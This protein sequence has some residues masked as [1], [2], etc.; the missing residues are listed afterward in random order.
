MVFK[1]LRGAAKMMRHGEALQDALA[2]A[3][4]VVVD[5]P[6]SAA[7][8]AVEAA[9]AGDHRPAADLLQRTLDTRAWDDRSHVVDVLAGASLRAPQ[10]LDDWES[11]APD[12]GGLA[13]VRAATGIH[14]A[15]EHRSRLRASD[16][17]Q[18]QLEAFH[19]TLA[20][21]T[22]LLQRAADLLPDDPEPWALALVHARGLEAPPEVWH[23]YLSR[24]R[25]ADP[26]HYGGHRAAMELLTAKWFG[27]HEEMS[28]FARRVAAEAP[29]DARVR[30]LPL[31]AVV[32]QIASGDAAA[33]AADPA[34]PEAVDLALA[35]VEAGP[36][37]GQHVVA[38]H[39][40][41]LVFVLFHC[42]S[43]R[44]AYD[45]LVATGPFATSVPW[46]YYGEART[47]FLEYRGHVVVKTAETM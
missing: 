25:A 24:V 6:T 34:T 47:V 5:A 43:F 46:G 14:R 4:S 13:L 15:W 28:D 21:T 11:A 17:S 22:A 39:R 9:L 44:Q 16:V 2:P 35:W 38:V 3:E 32:E 45:Q 1:A 26:W 10:W 33:A 42:R 29:E 41:A 18:E 7:A 23:D 37:R 36:D 40:N 12:D 20:D 19:T 30:A 27:S 8:A 31:A